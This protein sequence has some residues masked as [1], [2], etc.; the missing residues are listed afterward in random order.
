MNSNIKSSKHEPENE[1]RPIITQEIY[2]RAIKSDRSNCIIADAIREKYPRLSNIKVDIATIRCT[3]KKAGERYIYL[4]SPTMVDILLAYDQ[5]WPQKN[6]PI[7][8]RVRRPIKILPIT[9]SVSDKK[10]KAARRAA[11]ISEL[12]TKQEKGEILT[13]DEER[14]LTRLRNPRPAPDRPVTYGPP[15]VISTGGQDSNPIVHGGVPPKHQ[16]YLP[17]NARRFGAK[18]AQPDQITREAMDEVAKKSRQRIKELE[19]ALREAKK[20]GGE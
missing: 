6:L 7:K 5:G 9:R 13:A 3:D 18:S 1:L 14:A 16:N 10:A 4:T 17:S 8:L 19:K 12:E 15:K 20:K 11:R 2:D